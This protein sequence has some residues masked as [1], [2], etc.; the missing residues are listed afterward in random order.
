MTFRLLILSAS[1]ALLPLEGASY[2]ST[3]DPLPSP[4]ELKETLD[5][6]RREVQNQRETLQALEQKG[7]TQEDILE[8][9][10]AE[11]EKHRTLQK[12]KLKL[13]KGDMEAKTA[14]LEQ[15]IKGLSEHAKETQEALKGFKSRLSSLEK[16]LEGLQGA[17]S[18]LV[19]LMRV[20]Q[21]LAPTEGEGKVYKV[22]AGDSLEKI[23]KQNGT[24]LKALKELNQLTKDQ[25]VIGQT[26]KLPE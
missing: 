18:N 5:A 7:I 1:L 11:S 19:E 3:P 15:E 12:E 16:N 23:A 17:M 9:L 22:K 25:I 26:L 2:R 21:G 10:Q 14:S 24:T 20:S 8:A 4:R 6:L 13:Q